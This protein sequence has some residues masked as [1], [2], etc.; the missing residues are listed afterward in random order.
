MFWSS[1]CAAE[2][3]VNAEIADAAV[4]YRICK[5]NICTEVLD[6]QI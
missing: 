5:K 3:W 1:I 2:C 4:H 6:V